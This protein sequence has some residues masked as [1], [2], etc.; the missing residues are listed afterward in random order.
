MGDGDVLLVLVGFVLG[1]LGNYLFE[2]F[3]LKRR[4]AKTNRNRAVRRIEL[5]TMERERI[6]RLRDDKV[7]LVSEVLGRL[8]LVT[9]LWIA[10]EAVTN[11]FALIG[12]G[13]Y[14]LGA[15]T[16]S[17]IRGDFLDG[18]YAFQAGVATILLLTIVTYGVRT[19]RLWH[20]VTHYERYRDRVDLEIAELKQVVN[21]PPASAVD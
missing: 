5:L 13:S 15:L 16:D 20:R 10:Q 2:G 7:S 17:Y 6:E 18:L 11:L 9:L 3:G 12:S 14:A 4:A 19:Y 8:F 21:Q 1:V